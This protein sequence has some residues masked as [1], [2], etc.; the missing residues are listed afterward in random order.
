MGN[1]SQAG[2]QGPGGPFVD[3]EELDYACLIR[4]GY[5]GDNDFVNIGNSQDAYNNHAVNSA[6]L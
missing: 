1:P 2:S 6:F 5:P 4:T 3:L